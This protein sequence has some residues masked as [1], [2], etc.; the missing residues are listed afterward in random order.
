[1]NGET[2][3]TNEL[4]AMLSVRMRRYKSSQLGRNVSSGILVV[5]ESGKHYSVVFLKTVGFVPPTSR[6]SNIQTMSATLFCF[7]LFLIVAFVVFPLRIFP[8]F[9]FPPLPL[10]TSYLVIDAILLY[11]STLCLSLSRHFP[12]PNFPFPSFCYNILFLRCI[13][14]LN[15]SVWRRN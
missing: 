9:S 13:D 8:S 1:M 11:H 14:D 4:E 15:V 5:H 12:T 2:N 6:R 10:L 7:V 3:L